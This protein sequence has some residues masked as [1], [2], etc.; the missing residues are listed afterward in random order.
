MSSAMIRNKNRRCRYLWVAS[1]V[2]TWIILSGHV[3][4]YLK[5]LSI[6]GQ[7]HQPP[8]NH[9]LI[10]KR[11]FRLWSDLEKSLSLCCHKSPFLIALILRR[12][13]ST[14]SEVLSKY[15]V[16]FD[17]EIFRLEVVTLSAAA[18]A[19]PALVLVE[20]QAPCWAT[21]PYSFRE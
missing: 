16:D 11:R 18:A 2:A 12:S 19:S 5:L 15:S 6:A 17:D 20:S 3:R 9:R 4:P 13:R 7:Q 10:S 8:T 21:G 1:W 14:K